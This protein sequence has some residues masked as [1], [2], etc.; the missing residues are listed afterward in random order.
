M[1]RKAEKRREMIE[2]REE[3][4]RKKGGRGRKGRQRYI[5]NEDGNERK[6]GRR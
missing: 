1:A 6:K 2:N 5:E 4:D 3:S